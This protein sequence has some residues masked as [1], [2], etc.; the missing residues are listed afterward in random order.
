MQVT[1]GLMK[2]DMIFKIRTLTF[3]VFVLTVCSD[4][5]FAE[6][7]PETLTREQ[8]ILN[9]CKGIFGCKNY[10]S[11]VLRQKDLIL[12]SQIIVWYTAAYIDEI[13]GTKEATIF[14]FAAFQGML[15]MKKKEMIIG[16]VSTKWQSPDNVD[17]F[18]TFLKIA[19]K[20]AEKE[21]N[22]V[23]KYFSYMDYLEVYQYASFYKLQGIPIQ[24]NHYSVLLADMRLKGSFFFKLMNPKF[25]GSIRLT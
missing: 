25:L 2:T 12:S 21:K 22:V 6:T 19:M 20:N 10:S 5:G 7:F 23:E 15:A 24:Q 8:A 18:K 13:K 3:F 14:L 16:Q 9:A 17:K 4:F 11:E 1:K